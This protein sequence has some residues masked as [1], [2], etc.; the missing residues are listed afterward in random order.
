[1]ICFAQ[2]SAD[3]CSAPTAPLY[4]SEHNTTCRKTSTERGNHV[5]NEAPTLYSITDVC[6]SLA[7]SRS[8]AWQLVR[9]GQLSTVRIGKS[10]R[11]S[12]AELRRFV[13]DRTESSARH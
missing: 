12:V 6:K 1:M 8:T 7:V 11:V 9:S 5:N 13:A 3:D 4:L 2:S 10:V